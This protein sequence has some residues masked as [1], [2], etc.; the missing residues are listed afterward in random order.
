MRARR[1]RVAPPHCR[2]NAS[3]LFFKARYELPP[4]TILYAD[5]A[6]FLEFILWT[7]ESQRNGEDPSWSGPFP[8][9]E[10]GVYIL[11]ASSVSTDLSARRVCCLK[12]IVYSW[13]FPP[14]RLV[15]LR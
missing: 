15:G 4:G 7:P 9:S 5:F 3:D 8:A 2:A 11:E 6:A 14:G 10:P 12:S 13:I 1:G